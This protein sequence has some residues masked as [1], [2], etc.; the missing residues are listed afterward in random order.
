VALGGLSSDAP[1]HKELRA[2]SLLTERD[3]ADLQGLARQV[4]DR[5]VISSNEAVGPLRV[6]HGML[7]KARDIN[8]MTGWVPT[9]QEVR[10]WKAARENAERKLQEVEV[11]S[12]QAVGQI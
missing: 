10:D 6:I 5:T 12:R 4:N 3:I 2:F 7:Q 8:E 11:A 9:G 1:R